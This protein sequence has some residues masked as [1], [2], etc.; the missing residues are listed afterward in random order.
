MTTL[1]NIHFK[2]S[3]S[4]SHILVPGYKY[5]IKHLHIHINLR[6]S[7]NSLITLG[8]AG[9]HQPCGATMT[10]TIPSMKYHPKYLGAT[11]K[12][13]KKNIAV[14][15]HTMSYD[16]HFFHTQNILPFIHKAD[17]LWNDLHEFPPKYTHLHSGPFIHHLQS[18]I[19][20]HNIHPSI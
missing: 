17:T 9:Y 7:I 5:S 6:I 20:T 11:H 4:L 16:R 1:I 2:Q 18:T 10:L 15:I 12:H 13:Q 14:Q 8:S 3:T 19:F